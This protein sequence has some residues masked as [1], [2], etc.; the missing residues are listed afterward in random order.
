MDLMVFSSW[1]EVAMGLEHVLCLISLEDVLAIGKS[2][3]LGGY[4]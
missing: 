2:V 4:W 3:T 1:C